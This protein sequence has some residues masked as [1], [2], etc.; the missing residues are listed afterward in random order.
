MEDILKEIN[1]RKFD[2]L[3]NTKIKEKL[4]KV[5]QR[6]FKLDKLVENNLDY[7]T[8]KNCDD[9]LIDNLDSCFKDH[10]TILK[11]I[12]YDVDDNFNYLE[13]IKNISEL[14][15]NMN[16]FYDQDKKGKFLN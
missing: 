3:E 1:F 5:L 11:K 8:D 13:K 15:D 7:D 14:F 10:L 6:K 9:I 12:E 4:N 16:E 2:N